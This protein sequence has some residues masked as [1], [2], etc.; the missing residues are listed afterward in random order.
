MKLVKQVPGLSSIA[1]YR[2]MIVG[3]VIVAIFLALAMLAIVSG[4]VVIQNNPLALA[5]LATTGFGVGLVWFAVNRLE[6]KVKSEIANGYTTSPVGYFHLDEVDPRTGYVIREAGTPRLS[7][8]TRRARRAEAIALKRQSG[9]SIVRSR[10]S[11]VHSNQRRWGFIVGVVLSYIVPASVSLLVG[12]LSLDTWSSSAV[13]RLVWGPIVVTGVGA[14]WMLR[15]RS[16]SKIAKELFERGFIVMNTPE[17]AAVL[18]TFSQSKVPSVY[19]G[20]RLFW[21]AT[22]EGGALVFWESKSD[23]GE[24]VEL[25]RIDLDTVVVGFVSTKGVRS[26]RFAALALQLPEVLLELPI[27]QP[28]PTGFRPLDPAQSTHMDQLRKSSGEL[29]LR[30]RP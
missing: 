24:P 28:V 17:T 1:W 7:P 9:L 30:E 22:V 2:L 20:G 26:Y 4:K 29:I 16:D 5:A 13:F 10:R 18:A 23:E 19:L 21:L 6:K 3:I 12:G 25:A 27:A 14:I 11:P 8:A 15:S